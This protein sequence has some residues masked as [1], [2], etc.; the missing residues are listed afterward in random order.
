M[1]E[2]WV[3]LH[4]PEL[5]ALPFREDLVVA[6]LRHLLASEAPATRGQSLVEAAHFARYAL[7]LSDCEEVTLS[8]L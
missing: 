6:Y 2:R 5:R 3:R 7:N 4:H 8:A 1:F